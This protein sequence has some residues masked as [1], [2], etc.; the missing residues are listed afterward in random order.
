M[1]QASLMLYQNKGHDRLNF[2][3]GLLGKYL[4]ISR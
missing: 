4:R 1:N 2:F 3:L